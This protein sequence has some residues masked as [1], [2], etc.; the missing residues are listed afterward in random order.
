MKN[1]R[2]NFRNKSI[3]RITFRLSLLLFVISLTQE[4]FCTLGNNCDS[5]GYILLLI[6]W[7]GVFMLHLPAM[8]WLANP[9]LLF[10]WIF[11]NKKPKT[12]LTLSIISLLLTLSFLL[13][14]EIINNE[15]GIPEKITVIKLGYWLWVSSA[16]I[17]VI[18]NAFLFYKKKK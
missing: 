18:G 11:M 7:M 8:A 6:G 5:G 14:D 16:F 10:S 4:C 1:K 15:A 13:F 12:S 2:L 17:M 3:Q 9:V